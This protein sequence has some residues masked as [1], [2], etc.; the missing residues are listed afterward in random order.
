MGEKGLLLQ[1]KDG[2]DSI[3]VMGKSYQYSVGTLLCDLLQGDSKEI[4]LDGPKWFI[5]KY[6]HAGDD[7]NQYSID[8][9]A[10]DARKF[11][12][13]IEEEMP[14]TVCMLRTILID[15][16][17]KYRAVL[18]RDQVD[19]ENLEVRM[20][21]DLY[22]NDIRKE[23][24]PGII[25]FDYMSG[26]LKACYFDYLADVLDAMLFFYAEAAGETGTAVE[27]QDELRDRFL[28]ELGT[29]EH[30]DGIAVR[31]IYSREE[32][33]FYYQYEIRSLRAL[34][35]F[36]IMH[37]RQSKSLIRRC[38]NPECE[39]FFMSKRRN[40]MYC[41]YPSP[42]N[43]EKSCRDIY[44]RIKSEEKRENDAKTKMYRSAQ[45]RLLT[46]KKRHPESAEHYER[47]KKELKTH[48]DKEIA[49]KRGEMTVKAYAEWLDQFR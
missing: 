29:S 25:H 23:Y 41:S 5:S 24:L 10:A 14:I 22:N 34:A 3:A 48:I 36:E 42:Q 4:L 37:M 32:D 27:G 31:V 38:Q 21:N 7:V 1:Y 33:S 20:N 15:N 35:A 39:K 11:L 40:A 19:V 26:Y 16:I 9:A 12:T 45:S 13:N 30:I 47:L 2:V 44:P 49:V 18:D 43:Y 8:L 17:E 46:N 28:S 6:E